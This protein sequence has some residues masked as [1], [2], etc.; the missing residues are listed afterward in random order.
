MPGAW[1]YYFIFSKKEQKGIIVLGSI[2]LFSLLL[3]G[4]LPA[5]KKRPLSP[6]TKELKKS[7][8]YF[9]PNKI[10]SAEGIALGLSP[11]QVKTLLNYRRKGGVFYKKEGILKIYGIPQV[12]AHQLMPYVVIG[13][14]IDPS[15]NIQRNGKNRSKWGE[16]LSRETIDI[17]H[18]ILAD[19]IRI[20]PLPIYMVKR[21][22][23]YQQHLGSFQ[24][25]GQLKKVYGLT[26]SQ[27]QSIRPFLRFD[28]SKKPILNSE[29]MRYADWMALGIFEEREVWEILKMR[30]AN[31]GKITWKDLVIYFDLTEPEAMRLKE[32][33]RIN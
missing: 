25:I 13:P 6:I 29:S 16:G 4:L 20:V 30:K 1:K 17:N 21:I 12:L 15:S 14:R 26:D 23:N 11:R 32:S 7:L 19:W 10:D 9:D 33:V 31:G 18:P 27:Y 24:A 3:H 22:L 8:F 5:G 28:A 2:L